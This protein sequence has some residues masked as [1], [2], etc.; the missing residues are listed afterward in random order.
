MATARWSGSTARTSA[1]IP[2]QQGPDPRLP[3]GQV[4]RRAGDRG[5]RADRRRDRRCRWRRRALV[6][7]AP[8]PVLAS[9]HHV[10]YFAFDLLHVDGETLLE[11]SLDDAGHVFPAS[12]ELRPAA[13][14]TLDGSAADVMLPS[15]LGLEGVVAK[16]RNSRYDPV[17]A[18]ARG[19]RSSSIA[20]RSSSS[21][22]TVPVRWASTRS[23]LDT[24]MSAA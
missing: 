21:A 7:G 5:Q 10:V 3:G 19:A 15:G 23:S 17:F 13:L 1:S 16:R 4:G 12:C 14:E 11:R 18:P 9:G 20:S 22:A 24:T 2:Q 6:P 8:A